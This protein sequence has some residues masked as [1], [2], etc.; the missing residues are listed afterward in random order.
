LPAELV[1]AGDRDW[2][3]SQR[4]LKLVDRSAS[5][6]VPE[7]VLSAV[8]RV[9]CRV[10]VDW[11]ALRDDEIIMSAGAGT[12]RVRNLKRDPRGSG[13]VIDHDGVRHITI[14]GT[15]TIDEDHVMEDLT[16]LA[17]RQPVLSLALALPR[18]SARSRT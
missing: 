1:L 10:I 13:C 6:G 18:T 14:A 9:L 3:G 12:Q 4:G 17:C 5:Q 7:S 15:V 11:H 16:M 8:R 2:H